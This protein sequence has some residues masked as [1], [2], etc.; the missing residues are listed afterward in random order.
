MFRLTHQFFFCFVL[1]KKKLN[2]TILNIDIEDLALMSKRLLVSFF[3]YCTI[4]CV[5]SSDN[6]FQSNESEIDNELVILND[7]DIQL[8]EAI[9]DRMI[10]L[11]NKKPS[12]P[13]VMTLVQSL[14]QHSQN[15]FAEASYLLGKYYLGGILPFTLRSSYIQKDTLS[16]LQEPLVDV[17]FNYFIKSINSIDDSDW[18]LDLALRVDEDI[19]EDTGFKGPEYLYRSPLNINKAI[20]YFKLAASKGHGQSASLLSIL[21]RIAVR[22]PVKDIGSDQTNVTSEHL[23]HLYILSRIWEESKHETTASDILSGFNKVYGIN[24]HSRSCPVSLKKYTLAADAYFKTLPDIPIP[25]LVSFGDEE[26]DL[27]EEYNHDRTSSRTKTE[28]VDFI[29][30]HA[31]VGDQGFQRTAGAIYLSGGP[32][33]K[34]DYKA[35]LEYMKRCGE[36]D[37]VAKSVIG[38]MYHRGLGVEQD[39]SMAVKLYNESAEDGN[40]YAMM[41]LGLLYLRG[42]HFEKNIDKAYELMTA[43]VKTH[44]EAYVYLMEIHLTESN[45][46]DLD[47]VRTIAMHSIEL[48]RYNR[49]LYYMSRLEGLYSC[50]KRV[51]TFKE[52]MSNTYFMSIRKRAHQYYAKE[53]YEHALLLYDILATLGDVL[54]Q[55]NAAWMYSKDISYGL[56]PASFFNEENVESVNSEMQSVELYK[57]AAR[58]ESDSANLK[59]GDIYYYG[60]GVEK[61]LNKAAAY[62]IVG[63]GLKNARSSFNIGYMYQYG[64]GVPRNLFLAKTYYQ[65]AVRHNSEAFI[66]A[67]MA[68]MVLTIDSKRQLFIDLICLWAVGTLLAMAYTLSRTLSRAAN[69]PQEVVNRQN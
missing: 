21:S 42:I 61:N 28:I 51:E 32:G 25:T 66:P 44:H 47:K 4:I 37:H 69:R 64:E 12:N 1:R 27:E 56:T 45:H 31:D 38:Y 36:D 43:A 7:N 35:A 49:F 54:S 5:N 10:S 22:V 60:I 68:L 50:N 23:N 19:S 33:I 9:I 30:Y 63:A 18:L 14:E 2:C 55:K 6:D 13:E 58:Q 11:R 39:L 17:N 16:G 65:L 29:K 24:S 53:R 62:Y 3:L 20:Y 40:G 59:L 41:Q 52:L 46:F 67:T 26:I 8:L 48:S 15:G 34:R 57:L